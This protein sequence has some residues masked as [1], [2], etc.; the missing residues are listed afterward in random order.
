MN[1]TIKFEWTDMSLWN[2]YWRLHEFYF[3]TPTNELRWFLQKVGI[4]EKK[5]LNDDQII[6]YKN[7]GL[8]FIK[9]YE[10]PELYYIVENED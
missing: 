1:T 3:E 9:K 10:I 4:E 6:R 7:E 5:I 2:I 8:Y